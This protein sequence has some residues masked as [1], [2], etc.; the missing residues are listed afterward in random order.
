MLAAI[1]LISSATSRG[2]RTCKAACNGQ[3]MAMMNTANAS[4]AKTGS[5]MPSAATVR[6]AVPMPTFAARPRSADRRS[7]WTGPCMYPGSSRPSWNHLGSD[8]HAVGGQ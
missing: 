3:T 4:G 1:M 8:N 6:I 2:S 5:P 7:A